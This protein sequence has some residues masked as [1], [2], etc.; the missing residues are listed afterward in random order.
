MKE[1]DTMDDLKLR[2]KTLLEEIEFVH[3]KQIWVE[4]ISKLGIDARDASKL[5]AE[6]GHIVDEY[7]RSLR[8]LVDMLRKNDMTHIA[9]D[10]ADWAAYTLDFGVYKIEDPVAE[11]QKIIEKYLPLETEEEDD[12][13]DELE[14]PT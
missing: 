8:F 9:E 6:I 4:K 2:I 7:E 11:I 3:L 12:D 5:G 1:I 10:I 14:S 13:D